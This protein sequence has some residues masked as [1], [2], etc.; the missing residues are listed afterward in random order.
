[1]LKQATTKIPILPGTSINRKRF[2]RAPRGCR[3][4]KTHVVN[5]FDIIANVIL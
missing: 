4:A 1:M 3:N 2:S 5:V